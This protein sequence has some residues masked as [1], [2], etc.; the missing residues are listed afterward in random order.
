[1]LSSG[2]LGLAVFGIVRA[3][4]V[5]WGSL[6]TLGV[7]G[8]SIV[9]AAT[10][11]AYQKVAQSSLVPLR[12]LK[13]RNLNAASVSMLLLGAAWIP[14]WFF[15]NLYLQQV[16]GYGAFAA[17]AALL[18]MTGRA[19]AASGPPSTR[20]ERIVRLLGVGR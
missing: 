17:G 16:L 2:A 4:E 9:V 14:L 6:E 11:L 18:P 1:V 3:H 8:G 7:L 12:V 5:G 20:A 19:P 15:L 13:I 10:F